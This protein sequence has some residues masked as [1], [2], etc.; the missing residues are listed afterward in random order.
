MLWPMKFPTSFA[1]WTIQFAASRDGLVGVLDGM[2]RPLQR[3]ASGVLDVVRGVIDRVPHVAGDVRDGVAYVA[4]EVPEIEP[5]EVGLEHPYR[6]ARRSACRTRA[7]SRAG[8]KQASCPTRAGRRRSS[9]S[10][11]S[12]ERH[13]FR[14]EQRGNAR[15]G[16]HGEERD[17]EREPRAILRGHRSR[18]ARRRSHGGADALA[19]EHAR[20][21]VPKR[22]E[23]QR[24]DLVIENRPPAIRDRRPHAPRAVGE[25]KRERGRRARSRR[26]ARGRRRRRRSSSPGRHS[27]S[28]YCAGETPAK[29]SGRAPYGRPDQRLHE[30]VRRVLTAARAPILRVAV[31]VA[32]IALAGAVRDSPSPCAA[33]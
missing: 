21:V 1:A 27:T 29:R 12:C 33:L 5:V 20:E 23:P 18:R 13:P 30:A 14:D 31:L 19:R 25:A 9:R 2:P 17:A 7:R 22:D 16:R 11:G 6:R 8:Q 28:R 3:V 4:D 26:N 24:H 15:R 10:V 32:G